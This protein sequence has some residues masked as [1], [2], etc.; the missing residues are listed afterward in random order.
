V[1]RKL[2]LAKCLLVVKNN[3]ILAFFFESIAPVS[4]EYFAIVV[5]MPNSSQ[6]R[7]SGKGLFSSSYEMHDSFDIYFLTTEV[8]VYCDLPDYDF[9][10]GMYC[11]F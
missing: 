10:H 8:I 7:Q 3:A 9:N 2:L 4:Q 5:L 6:Y 1:Q 11:A